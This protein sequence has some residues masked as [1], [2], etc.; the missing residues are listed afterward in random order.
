M[1]KK[2]TQ[3]LKQK[4]AIVKIDFFRYTLEETKEHH[5]TTYKNYGIFLYLLR[6]RLN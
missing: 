1:D 5:F 6:S 4:S 2:I 3:I